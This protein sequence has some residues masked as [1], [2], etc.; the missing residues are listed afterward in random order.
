MSVERVIAARRR[1]FFWDLSDGFVHDWLP[2]EVRRLDLAEH[3]RGVL[4]RFSGPLGGDELHLGDSPRL[5]ATDPRN[6]RAGAFAW[7]A[8]HDQD[9]RRRFLKNLQAWGLGPEV[10]VTGG[11]G[12]S[13][14]LRA[15]L[16]P[17]VRHPLGVFPVLSEARD[18]WGKRGT[19]DRA[20]CGVAA[21]SLL[22]T[23]TSDPKSLAGRAQA[24]GNKPI[25][26]E[27]ESSGG[28][29]RK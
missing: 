29:R 22:E 26:L 12:L 28:V 13:P 4:D 11:S 15:E 10:V 23:G 7:V 8:R 9:H 5:G 19:I 14:A 16:W 6:D 27:P 3:R 20:V 24:L 1:D 2:R 25:L 21:G 18:K 17:G